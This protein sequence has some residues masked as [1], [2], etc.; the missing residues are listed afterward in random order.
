MEKELRN[1]QMEIITKGAM[2][3]ESQKAMENT[4]GPQDTNTKAISKTA[5][6]KGKAHGKNYHQEVAIN[7]KENGLMTKNADMVS[8]Y[9][10]LEI[11][12]KANILMILDMDM[13]RCTGLMGILTR[14]T[15]TREFKMAMGRS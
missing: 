10:E 2:P 11:V 5:L 1:L 14:E 8:M 15:G 7:M 6:D 4:I 13:V 3:M 9:G 12:I